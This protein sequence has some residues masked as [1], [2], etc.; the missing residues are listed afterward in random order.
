MRTYSRSLFMIKCNVSILIFD[1]RSMIFYIIFHYWCKPRN[2]HYCTDISR[3]TITFSHLVDFSNISCIAIAS[4][5]YCTKNSHIAQQLWWLTTSLRKWV[6]V[7]FTLPFYS[8]QRKC[9]IFL[10]RHV[11]WHDSDPLKSGLFTSSLPSYR[12]EWQKYS[13]DIIPYRIK[14]MIKISR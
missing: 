6:F 7:L 11:P 5:F 8:M 2:C 1:L 14:G 12:H 4:S 13:H 10:N 3:Y 9:F